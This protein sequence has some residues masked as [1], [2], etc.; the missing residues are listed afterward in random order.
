MGKCAFFYSASKGVH[1]IIKRPLI[2]STIEYKHEYIP[3]DELQDGIRD[4]PVAHV[5]IKKSDIPALLK[6]IENKLQKE[7]LENSYKETKNDGN[8]DP[9]LSEK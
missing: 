6:F 7:N 4:Y 1:K 5:G 8:Q 3:A 2:N 9:P